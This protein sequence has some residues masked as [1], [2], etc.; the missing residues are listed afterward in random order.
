MKKRHEEEPETLPKSAGA[1]R[2]A[3]TLSPSTMGTRSRR[4]LGALLI[5]LG[6]SVF[7]S[8]I[9]AL[10]ADSASGEGSLQLTK[11]EEVSEL[12]IAVMQGSAQDVWVKANWPKAT[13][14]QFLAVADNF[15]AVETGKADASIA[16]IDIIK[17]NLA[18]RPDLAILGDPIYSLD[19]GAGFR[20]DNDALRAQFDAFVAKIRA[21]GTLADM[22]RRWIDVNDTTMPAI[23]FAPDAP[24]LSVG[25]A[26]VGLPMVSVK[27]N[28]LVGFEVEMAQ[29]FAA[30]IGRRPVWS[31]MD[32]G[33]LIAALASGKID[34]IITGMAITPERRQRIDFSESYHPYKMHVF[35]RAS[36][37][38]G[39]APPAAAAKPSFWQGL[40]TSF[41]DNIIRE[42]R[43]LLLWNGLKTTVLLAILSCLFG[44]LLGALVCYMRM[45]ANVLLR[46]SAMVYISVIRGLP[47]LVLLML[48]FYVVFASVN[49][50]PVLVAVFAFGLNFAAYVSEMFRTGIE[51]IDR[52]QS[53]AGI[54]MGFSRVGTFRHIVLPQ[55]LQRILPVYQGEFISMVKMTAVVGYVAVEDLTKASDI[56]RSRTFD[57]FFP[58][59]TVAVLYFLISW[60]MIQALSYLE[61]RTDPVR[62]RAASGV[63]A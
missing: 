25:N 24:P 54:A 35:V 22:E 2:Y 44:T 6:L 8:G 52:G 28:E 58:L 63:R 57:A 34:V 26:I 36:D 45:S 9:P 27:D 61:R 53:E 5:G 20:Q 15:V 62:R 33:G 11:P 21:D 4:L 17:Q 38:A 30:S 19:V 60:I 37:I 47:V 13:V 3:L 16:P 41:Y 39:A 18:T 42:G 7:A 12:R 51:S 32:F 40:A 23:E 31:T 46:R 50:D 48:I 55:A 14:L 10:A 29:R 49:I 1:A 59:V 56:I 43:Y